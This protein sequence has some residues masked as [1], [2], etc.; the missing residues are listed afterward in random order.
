MSQWPTFAKVVTEGFG[1]KPNPSVK[2]TEME[3]GVPKQAVINKKVMVELNIT[4][5]FESGADVAMFENWYYNDIKRV[6]F[7]SFRHP[8]TKQVLQCRI[9]S[10]DIGEIKPVISGFEVC[11]T[12]MTLEYLK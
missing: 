2:R 1:E 3:R 12:N 9:K 4:V 5:Q 11:R 10:G 6:S 7:F 8:R